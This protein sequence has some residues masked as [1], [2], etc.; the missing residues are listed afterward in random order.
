MSSLGLTLAVGVTCCMV[1]AL[2]WLP[3]ALRSLDSGRK[4][5]AAPAVIPMR[6]EKARAA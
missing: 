6:A 5:A 3:A 1:A 2:V 4:P